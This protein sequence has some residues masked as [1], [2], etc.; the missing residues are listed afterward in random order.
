MWKQFLTAFFCLLIGSTKL[1]S[2]EICLW[3][4]EIC[5]E[6]VCLKKTGKN[7]QAVSE[8]INYPVPDNLRIEILD[9]KHPAYRDKNSRGVFCSKPIREGEILGEYTGLLRS[10]KETSYTSQYVMTHAQDLFID[11]KNYGNETRFINDYRG[12]APGPNV[13][14]TSKPAKPFCYKGKTYDNVTVIQALRDIEKNEEVLVN[15][16]KEY[17]KKW[18]II[19][20][21]N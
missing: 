13:R 7:F 2:S 12:I 4:K 14:F 9:P 5:Y 8:L 16:G 17:C 19:K 15:Y 6:E 21:D 3:P 20:K 18:G 11:A 1:Y 10:E